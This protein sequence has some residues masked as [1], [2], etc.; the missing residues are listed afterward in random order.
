MNPQALQR[1][2]AQVVARGLTPASWIPE[3]SE[4]R[5]DEASIRPAR[6]VEGHAV[7]AHAVGP[8]EPW[9]GTVAFLDGI[10]R[11]HIVAHAGTAPLVIATIAAAVRERRERRLA[12][13][14]HGARTLAVGRAEALNA[15]GDALGD[16][17]RI[18]LAEDGPVHPV[19]DLAAVRRAVDQER[20]RLELEV[21]ARYPRPENSWLVVDGGLSES[22]AWAADGRTI[23][24]VKSHSILPFSGEDLERYL[25]LPCGSRSSVFA[26][27]SSQVAPV[28]SWALRLWPWEGKDLFYGLIRVEAAPGEATVREADRISRWLLAER[29]PVSTP[30]ARWDRLLYGIHDVEGFLRSSL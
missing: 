28:Y 19:R 2:R 1:I 3:A 20:G 24:I 30:D 26:P 13:A 21:G 11:Y 8:A 12:T 27:A 9:P 7:A 15:A 10:Q 17:E 14:V 18:T 4:G 6:L 25:K 29:A 5:I 22:P 23:G 16:L